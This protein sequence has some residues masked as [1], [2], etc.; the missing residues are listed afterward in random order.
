M[1][2]SFSIAVATL[3]TVYIYIIGLSFNGNKIYADI[4]NANDWKNKNK[5]KKKT[6]S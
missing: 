3:T 1:W 2:I 4:L 5:N 6:F